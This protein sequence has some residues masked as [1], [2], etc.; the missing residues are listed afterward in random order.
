MAISLFQLSLRMDPQTTPQTQNL[1][2][3]KLANKS[4]EKTEIMWREPKKDD[5]QG[6]VIQQLWITHN[7]QF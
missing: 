6:K 2:F 7:L 5:E 1:M 4:I 3:S